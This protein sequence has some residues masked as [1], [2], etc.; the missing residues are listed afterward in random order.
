MGAAMNDDHIYIIYPYYDNPKML[1]IQVENWQRYSGDLQSRITFMLIDDC[2]PN[3]P[4]EP[5]FKELRHRKL[6]YRVTKN[7]PWAQHHARNV[8]AHEAKGDNPWLFMSDMDIVLTPEACNEMVEKCINGV[9]GAKR[10]HTFERSYVGNVREPKYHCNTFLVKKR[11][12]W[13][14]NGY[15]VD[16]CGAYGGDGRFLQ[17]LH[18]VAPQLHHGFGSKHLKSHVQ[19]TEDPITLWG[20]ELEA[21]EDANT[22]EWGR[23]NSEFHK[24]YRDILSEK[25]AKGDERS[26]NP[27]RYPYEQ[28]VI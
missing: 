13:A 26:L 19:C 28:I 9:D 8:G 22:R 23:K 27:I 6:L 2:S 12:Y 14:I 10:F 17:Q 24:K 11:N 1:E 20:Y 18:Q 5:I 16:Y 21:C 15:D 3:H 4:A 7:V 25:R